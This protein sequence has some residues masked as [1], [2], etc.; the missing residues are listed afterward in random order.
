MSVP[1]LKLELQRLKEELSVWQAR[2]ANA[3][4]KGAPDGKPTKEES[5]VNG[6]HDE[7]CLNSLLT[8]PTQSR[9]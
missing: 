5:R 7:W 3:G 1:E 4:R 8:V 6:A 2:A 9:E